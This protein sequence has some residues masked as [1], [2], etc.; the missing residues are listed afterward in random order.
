MGE[1]TC[2]LVVEDDKACREVL[3]FMLRKSTGGI[4][5]SAENGKE[6]LSFLGH[7]K[8][9]VVISDVMMPEVNGLM[10]M[11]N[12]RKQGIE[13]PVIFVSGYCSDFMRERLDAS[14]AAFL[15]KPLDF[16]QLSEEIK[17]CLD[18]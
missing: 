5:V 1:K 3:E 10:L 14:G 12:M 6:A 11:E 4:V 18:C 8:P 15:M 13:V 2:I 16:K 9:H 7:V 17:S